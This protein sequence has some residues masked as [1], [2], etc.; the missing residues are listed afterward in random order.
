MA[1][2]QKQSDQSLPSNTEN[3][4]WR[5]ENEHVKKITLRLGKALKKPK[6]SIFEEENVLVEVDEPIKEECEQNE[7]IEITK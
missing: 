1:M 4:P 2:F 3:N 6:E 5:D 7:P